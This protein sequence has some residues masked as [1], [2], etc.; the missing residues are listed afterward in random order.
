M[1]VVEEAGSREWCLS[2]C[3]VFDSRREIHPHQFYSTVS[4]SPRPF[5][6]LFAKF[7][8]RK[9]EEGKGMRV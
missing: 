8:V 2:A 5:N 1:E 9:G 4:T 6:L 3:C 7:K